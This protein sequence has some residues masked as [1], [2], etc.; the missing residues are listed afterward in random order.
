[1]CESCPFQQCRGGSDGEPTLEAM[2]AHLRLEAA[3]VATALGRARVSVTVT[4][5]E[6]TQF[7]T[8]DRG[9]PPLVRLSPH[10]YN[11]KNELEYAIEQIAAVRR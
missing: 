1:M 4:V 3:N 5:P 6:D 11:T 10:Y 9:L 2:A 7:D 8:E